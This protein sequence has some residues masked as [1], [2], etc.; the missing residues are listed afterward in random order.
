MKKYIY[1]VLALASVLCACSRDEEN[2]FDKSAAERAQEALDNANAVLPMYEGGWEMIYFANPD[3]K[4]YNL[5]LK[6]DEDSRATAIV[7]NVTV[8]YAN[9]ESTKREAL[10]L[11]APVGTIVT[12]SLST[13]K[14]KLDNG[15][16]LSFDTYNDVFHAW[17]DPRENGDGLLGDYEFLILSADPE[18]IVLK[19]QKHGGYS[20]LRPMKADITPEDYFASCEKL[21]NTYFGNGNIMTL[22]KNGKLY[23][24][25]EGS[26]GLFN[27]TPYGEKV[28]E[29]DPV[30]YPLCPT[31]DGIMLCYGFW[32]NKNERLFVLK[33]DQFI[34]E[35]GS[36]INSGD[37]GRLF[38]TY[39]DVNKG[40]K[41]D[42]KASTGAITEV[43]S[44]FEAQ[45]KEVTKDN[46]AKVTSIAYTYSDTV[47]RYEGSL[48]LRMKFEYKQNGKKNTSIA[49]YAID[50]THETGG[51]TMTFNKPANAVGTAW[52]NNESVS[53]IKT[54]INTVL[55]TFVLSSKDP[56]NP[57]TALILSK[58]GSAIQCSGSNNLK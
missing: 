25:H 52:Y 19:G 50:I 36:V 33:D 24:L 58:E 42:L 53:E 57:T 4:G 8:E 35:Q 41:A 21:L 26:T 28:P 20:I 6:F 51:V 31:L 1:I 16:V 38:L 30:L 2:I 7:K 32:E 46:N 11:D 22:N 18:R 12:D 43:I 37:L 49:D 29:A 47:F 3:S 56:I 40:W 34:G 27:V 54:L 39:I 14:A 5:I 17:A 10:V 15:P 9:G 13:W 48:I 45:I 44:T 23:Y 55:G